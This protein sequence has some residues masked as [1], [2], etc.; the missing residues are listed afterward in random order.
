MALSIAADGLFFNNFNLFYSMETVLS[1]L[2]VKLDV[3]S[4]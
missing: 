3:N 1:I 2:L 4:K